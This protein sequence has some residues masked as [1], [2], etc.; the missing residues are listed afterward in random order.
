MPTSL[1]FYDMEK[2]RKSNLQQHTNHMMIQ[3]STTKKQVR[4]QGIMMSNTATLTLFIR[5]IVKKAWKQDG[6][7]VES[8]SVVEAHSHAG[9]LEISCHSPTRV[10]LPALQSTESKRNT[11]YRSYLMNVYIQNHWSTALKLPGNTTQTKIVLSPETPWT[12]YNYIYLEDYR[13]YGAKYWWQNWHTIKTRKH[14]R[15]GTQCGIQY[16]TNRNPAQSLQENAITVFG[17]RL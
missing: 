16:P 9:T 4:Y 8:V 15:H 11:S 14:L 5:N 10:L 12:L 1:N 3:T 17:P 6:M 2:N 13:A 7:G